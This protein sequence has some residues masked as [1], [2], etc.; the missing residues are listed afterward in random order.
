MFRGRLASNSEG[1]VHVSWTPG[2][3][4]GKVCTCFVDA[5]RPPQ[6]LVNLWEDTKQKYIKIYYY[7]F[8]KI[9]CNFK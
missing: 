8:C 6:K 1:F 7:F 9:I 3:Q 5:R 2:V 4:V